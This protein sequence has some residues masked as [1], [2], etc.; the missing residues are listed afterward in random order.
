MDRPTVPVEGN[1]WPRCG[2]S[3]S[4]TGPRPAP[5]GGPT[6]RSSRCCLPTVVVVSVE[7]GRCEGRTRIRLDTRGRLMSRGQCE[8]FPAGRR[9]A[10]RALAEGQLISSSHGRR[11]RVKTDQALDWLRHARKILPRRPKAKSPA[12]GGSATPLPGRSD[13]RAGAEGPDMGL[14]AATRTPPRPSPTAPLPGHAN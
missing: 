14:L 7:I 3:Q 12:K 9:T 4:R 2:V 1:C 10:A 13:R 5:R 8:S 11:V 6:T